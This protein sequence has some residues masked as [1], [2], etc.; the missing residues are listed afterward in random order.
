M[1]G[2]SDLLAACLCRWGRLVPGS[3]AARLFRAGPI[4]A[5]YPGGTGYGHPGVRRDGRWHV[6]AAAL[7]GVIPAAAANQLRHHP[8]RRHPALGL[9]REPGCRD[10]T[11]DL[12]PRADASAAARRLVMLVVRPRPA[13][14]LLSALVLVAKAA[15]PALPGIRGRRRGCRGSEPARRLRRVSRSLDS[16]ARGRSSERRRRF[17]QFIGPIQEGY[18]AAAITTSSGER[19]PQ[20][21]V[22]VHGDRAGRC[23]CVSFRLRPP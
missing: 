16:R 13:S 17:R 14:L 3:L 21:L 22:G 8:A 12:H 10:A 2:D 9:V 15:S 18:H 11:L 20:A 19:V 1:A 23:C 7:A 4:A 5:E 6:A